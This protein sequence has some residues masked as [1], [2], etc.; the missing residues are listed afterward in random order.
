MNQL[1]FA[2]PSILL[3]SIANTLLKW[4]MDR[5]GQ[6][7]GVIKKISL[8]FTDPVI[9]ISVVATAFSVIWWLSIINK[10][11]VSIVYP[12]IQAGVIACTILMSLVFLGEHLSLSQSL[13][14]A[15]LSIGI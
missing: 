6:G 8:I 2:L 3:V 13:G 5:L 12:V 15:I 14:L 1:W 11:Q 4:R 9:F 7:Y 10:V